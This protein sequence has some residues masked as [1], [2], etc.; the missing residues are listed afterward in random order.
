MSS[1]AKS[2]P[3]EARS[4][5][6]AGCLPQWQRQELPEPL[7]FTFRNV[8][9]TIGPGAILLAGSIGGG[10]W[11]VGPLTT[12]RYGTGILWVATLGIFLQMIFNLEAIRYTLYTGE[13]ILTGIMRLRPGR[14]LWGPFYMAAGTLQ[15]ATPA[16][17]LGCANVLFTA[18]KGELPDPTGGDRMTLFL[19]SLAVLG[20]TVFLLQCGKSI[21]RMLER[22]SWSMVIFIFVFLVAANV[23]FVPADIWLRTAVGF[24]SPGYLPPNMDW[25]LLG[26]FA[27]TAGS[28]GLGNLAV[29]NLVRDKGLGMAHWSGSIGGMLSDDATEV[30]PIGQV[31]EVTAGNLQRWRTWWSYLLVDQSVLWAL[32]CVAGMF[33]NVNLAQAIVSP[34]EVPPDNAAGA[35]Q[36]RYMAE[37]MWSGF[38]FL[39]LLNGFWILFST[40]LGN[41]DCLTRIC[42]DTLWAGWP[43]VRRQRAR[44]V[45]FLLLLG[46]AAWGVFA[47]A[48]GD[49]ALSLFRILGLLASPILAVGAIQI[50]LVN[51][52]FLPAQLR[53][54]LWRRVC[55]VMCGVV[56]GVLAVVSLTAEYRKW[57]QPPPGPA[58]NATE[59]EQI[60]STA[61]DQE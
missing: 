26:V 56:Y 44:R 4:D 12:V 61:E 10:E 55:L 34:G 14:W 40:Q 24:V 8:L 41:T 32:G 29:S 30:R 28:G 38:W 50:L 51:L 37:K 13:P 19:V 59:G 48:A 46:F 54:P 22:L 60:P 25:V 53:P 9:R 33:L 58:T 18:G 31:F 11:I 1:P 43:A 7:P 27:A 23:L 57:T 5:R 52:S 16:L 47:L 39:A 17:A 49:S 3:V 45:Y 6:P 42:T 21:E 20:L 2:T 35:F 36:A 15:L